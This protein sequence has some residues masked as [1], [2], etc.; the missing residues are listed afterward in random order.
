MKCLV[1]AAGGIADEPLVEGGGKAPLETA[2]TPN[3]DLMSSRGI[4]G[5][6][7]TV[8]PGLAPGNDL[9]TLAV[10]GYAPERYYGG[11]APL[12][13][14]GQGVTLGA[15]EVGI[16]CQ[17]VRFDQTDSGVEILS[18]PNGGGLT[19][20]EERAL[21]ADLGPALGSDAFVLHPGPGHRHLLVWRGGERGVRTTPP[22]EVTNK[23][24]AARLPEGRGADV[25]RGIMERA[26]GVLSGHPLCA[27]RRS[28][29]EPAPNALWLWGTGTRASLPPFRERFGLDGTVVS[30]ADFV[31]GIGRLAGMRVVDVPDP[32]AGVDLALQALGD[33]DFVFLGAEVSDFPAESGKPA[34]AIEQFDEHVVGP[35]LTGLRALGDDWRLMVIPPTKRHTAEPVPFTVYVARDEGKDRGISRGFS[36]RDAR[37]FGIFIP[38]AHTLLERLLRR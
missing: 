36:E 1:V 26:Q 7:R 30:R 17:L 31:H 28:R 20:E 18:D 24:V 12:A 23:P 11:L 2:R 37:E 19:A 13:A 27:G 32:A 38:E 33:H 25:L 21:L 9:G 22:H 14:A 29:G 5:L 35:A 10:L 3:L 15:D 6:T 8:P 4:L 16:C 34:D